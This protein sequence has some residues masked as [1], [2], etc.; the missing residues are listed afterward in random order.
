MKLDDSLDSLAAIKDLAATSECLFDVS[1][2]DPRLRPVLFKSRSNMSY[3]CDYHSFVG[4]VVCRRWSID[5]C[6]KYLWGILFNWIYNYNA[7]KEVLEYDE[8]IHQLKRWSQE[9]LAYKCVC[10]HRP[11]RMMKDVDGVCRRIDPLIH[12]Y[13]VDATVMR[14]KDIMLR[15]FAYNFNIFSNFFN[16]RHV[17]KYDVSTAIE[18]VSTIPTPLSFIII[19]YGSLPPCSKYP[20]KHIFHL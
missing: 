10:I 13:L 6:C 15:P 9:L 1:L 14:S 19:Q 17:S 20:H 2:N 3:E 16:P 4:E 18:T 5:A 7:V 11:N 12:R 8:G